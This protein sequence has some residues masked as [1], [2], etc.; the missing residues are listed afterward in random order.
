MKPE[1]FKF[2]KECFNHFW[3]DKNITDKFGTYSIYTKGSMATN[4][5]SGHIIFNEAKHI[6]LTLEFN[7][8][9]AKYG[10]HFT[11]FAERLLTTSKT[12][13][14]LKKE[15]KNKE[16]NDL[17]SNM[18]STNENYKFVTEHFLQFHS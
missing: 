13:M 3:S 8:N 17:I 1:D 6:L 2:L 4:S 11:E 18:K 7:L 5:N 15:G 12:I 10:E 9:K 16:I 14:A